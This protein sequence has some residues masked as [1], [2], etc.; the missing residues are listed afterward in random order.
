MA[1]FERDINVERTRA[2]LEAARARGHHGGRKPADPDKVALA[3]KMYADKSYSIKE[4][5]QA[6]GLSRP[7]VFRYV[8]VTPTA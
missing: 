5:V 3:R 6:T 8:K 4:I 2:G 1:E 7:T